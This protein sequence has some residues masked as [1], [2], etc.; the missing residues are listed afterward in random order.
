MSPARP[1]E[2]A[3]PPIGR[4]ARSARGAHVRWRTW[5]ATGLGLGLAATAGCSAQPAA[6]PPLAHTP[7][8]AKASRAA[9]PAGP[10]SRARKAPQG[11]RKMD[12]TLQA[13]ALAA[14]G[15]PLPLEVTLGNPGTGPLVI[16]DPAQ[17]LDIE[18]HF[19]DQQTREDLSFTLG[20]I[21]TTIIGNVDEYAIE[22]PSPKPVTIPPAGSLIVKADANVRV[23][24]RPGDYQAF[25]THQ[26][27]E[28]NRV[29]VKVVYTRDSVTVLFATAHDAQMSYGRREWAAERLA[30]LFPAFRLSLPLPDA[31]AATRAEQE[32]ANQ[33]VYVKFAA[34]WRDQLQTADLDERLD[35]LR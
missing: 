7:A 18:Y 5:L 33:A 3:Q 2:G 19:I 14:L 9:S 15:M 1:P 22:L 21:T 11:H 16:D 24:L 29:P 31:P 8:E 23:F 28:S 10:A 12:I 32:A 26:G 20:K 27:S 17:S 13:P 6:S 34:W 35:K 30:R 4:Q 25:V